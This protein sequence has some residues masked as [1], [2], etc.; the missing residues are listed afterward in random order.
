MSED[1]PTP[2]LR[3]RRIHLHGVGPDRARF[4][5]LDLDF[6]TSD[7][8]ASRV[9]LSLTNTGGK[10]TLITLVTSLIVPSSRAQVGGRQLGDYVLTGDTSHVVCEWE[11]ETT[12]VRMV[13]GTVMEWKDGR[14]QPGPQQRST[15][16]MYRRW[17]LFRTR[18]DFPGIDDLPFLTEGRRTTFDQY[19]TMVKE[20]LDPYPAA[21]AVFAKT[22]QEWVET[23]E[24]QTNIDPVLVG[25]QM[26]MNDSEAGAEKLLESFDSP[27]HVVRFFVSALNDEQHL[28]DFT[29][30]LRDYAELAVDRPRLEALAAFCEQAGARVERVARGGE[31]LADA[32]REEKQARI[33]GGE[34]ATALSNRIEQDRQRCEELA[35]RKQRTQEK[36]AELRRKFSQVSDIRMQLHLESARVELAA[37]ESEEEQA[38]KAEEEHG[39]EARA[40]EAVQLVLDISEARARVRTAQ[41]AYDTA[42]QGM[43]P[44]RR[45]ADQAA[46]ALAARLD[47]LA[48]EAER[49]AEDADTRASEAT[50]EQRR[51]QERL[52]EATRRVDAVRRRIDTL[53]TTVHESEAAYE[54]AV[55]AGWIADG[56]PVRDCVTRWTERRDTAR[57]EEAEAERVAEEA[58][59]DFDRAEADIEELENELVSLREKAYEHRSRLE[60]FDGEVAGLADDEV[61]L[62]V[63]GAPP[64]D[65]A[66][67]RRAADLTERAAHE[68]EERAAGHQQR[69]T[70]A[71]KEVAHLDEAGTAPAGPDTLAVLRV[72]TEANIGAVTGLRWIEKNV[73]DPEARAAYIAAHPELAGGVVV[74]DPG[75]FDEVTALLAE[76]APRTRTT[77]TVTVAADEHGTTTGDAE[78]FHYVV[79]PHRATWDAEWAARTRENLHR[80]AV[81][82]GEQAALARE[83]ARRNRA[84]SA[85]CVSFANR[86]EETSREKLV[87]RAEEADST[88]RARDEQRT[89]RMN[90]RQRHRQEAA[91]ARQNRDRARDRA[92]E[93]EQWLVK[94]EELRA[95]VEAAERARSEKSAGEAELAQANSEVD[96][97]RRAER[98]YQ[99]VRDSCVAEAAEQRANRD[100]WLKE[101]AQLGTAPAAVDPG[102]SLEAVRAEW[103]TA[104][105]QRDAAERGMPEALELD[106]AKQLLSQ[107][108]VRRERHGTR[109]WKRAE[110]LS[111]TSAASS[112]AS[113]NGALTRA[114]EAAR[115]AE[116]KRLEAQ[117]AVERARGHLE[118]VRPTDRQ[119]H[120]DLSRTPEWEP[121][122]PQEIPSVLERLDTYGAEVRRERDEAENEVDEVA[123]LH[124]QLLKDIEV[125][126]DIVE[127]WTADRSPTTHVFQG[128]KES[129]RTRMLEL[130]HDHVSKNRALNTAQDELREAVHHARAVASDVRWKDLGEPV[131]VRIRSL[132]EPDLVGESSTLAERIRALGESA[133]GD[134]EDLDTHRTILRDDL[135]VLCREQRRLLREV[136]RSS[137]LPV[138]L[139]ELSTQPAIRIRFADAP[140]DEAAA[141]LSDRI[142]TWARELAE[143][144]K[145]ATSSDARAR[146]LAD[147]VRDTVVNRT[148]AGAWSIDILKPSI[149]GQVFYCTPERIPYEFS[150]GQELTLAVLVYCALSRVRAAHRVG[151]PRPP[152]TLILDNPF[153]S[154]SAETLIAMQHRLAAHTGLQIICA[155]GLHDTGVDA[156]FTGP[157]SV[158]VKLRNDGDQRRNLSFLRLRAN[159]VDGV[160]VAGAMTGGRDPSASTNWVDA[161][162]YE[163]GR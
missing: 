78:R 131:V 48:T 64:A 59:A 115:S 58:E 98:E 19:L 162:R 69:A 57:Q 83:A 92:S 53:E 110:E 33:S 120:V 76:N 143:N 158:I 163:V 35:L 161:L 3:L 97:A 150:G 88:L 55:S 125:F 79:V 145:R 152:G 84:C 71:Q 85:A 93:A 31:A 49:K 87:A 135:I 81:H 89:Q 12:G 15:T 40:W 72:I 138:G 36:A 116:S 21:Q 94:A 109:E 124:D 90:E 82:E 4:D 148:R 18:P 24:R 8:A 65:V 62:S 39:F 126:G 101:R 14:R 80:T 121:A 63:L 5:P 61:L 159:V 66:S 10:S 147:A 105:N 30:K 2:P 32:E 132:S 137:Q 113:L 44:L 11:D 103:E 156:A 100:P 139:G 26:R 128:T 154:A 68:S 1:L 160:D 119:N 151:G 43:E 127:I 37:A 102:G 46:A 91:T 28:T 123:E 86:W 96:S 149:D 17:Y 129:A 34:H 16:N 114:K 47:T 111:E 67:V 108:E 106:H 70:E 29:S 27:D 20:L 75:R 134:L 41:R 141:R 42:E 157:G 99:V 7:G 60:A 117:S 112:A 45:R 25:Y 22:Q 104:R 6:A 74:S 136:V 52:Q 107:W 51:A 56:E 153:G 144:P 77:V 13:T 95:Q 142:D 9:L 130:R 133:T 155:T 73:P 23:L 38:R 118:E 140:D 146:W 122:T 50:E 54:A